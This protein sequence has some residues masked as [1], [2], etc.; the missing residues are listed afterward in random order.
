MS[1]LSPRTNK[2][3]LPRRRSAPCTCPRPG[4]PDGRFDESVASTD[5]LMHGAALPNRCRGLLESLIG[6]LWPERGPAERDRRTKKRTGST[7]RVYPRN[8][9]LHAYCP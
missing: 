6:A 4:P 3:N 9:E 5:E 7:S 8:T 2:R 1:V